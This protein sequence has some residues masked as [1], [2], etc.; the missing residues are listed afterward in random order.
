MLN[1][2]GQEREKESYLKIIVIIIYIM[3][4]TIIIILWWDGS[5]EIYHGH[6]VQFPY[7]I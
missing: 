4:T 7:G 3:I 5:G 1:L 2:E 6:N